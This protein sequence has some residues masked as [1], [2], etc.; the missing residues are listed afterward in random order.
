MSDETVRGDETVRSQETE[1][2]R[3]AVDFFA[4]TQCA[5]VSPFYE[6]VCRY[7]VTDD[8]MLELLLAAPLEQR[9]P[10]L[11]FGA[12]NHLVTLHRDDP[13]AGYFPNLGGAVASDAVLGR[14]LTRFVH[15]HGDHFRQLL[16]TRTT[17]TNDVRRSYV[18]GTGLSAAAQH[19]P[20]PLDVVELGASAGLNLL[21][22]RYRHTVNDE[23]VF[24]PARAET[25]E[26]RILGKGGKGEPGDS[27]PAENADGPGNH[28]WPIARTRTGVDLQP[29]DIRESEDRAWL[30][31]FVWPE[32]TEELRTLDAAIAVARADGPPPVLKADALAY[33]GRLAESPHDGSSLVVFTCSLLTY[34][35]A[36]RSRRILRH[37]QA[38]ARTRPVAWLYAES[39]LLA[40][41][42]GLA[43]PELAGELGQVAETYAIGLTVLTGDRRQ[44]MLLG[45]ADPYLR[46][47][48]SV[49]GRK[50]RHGG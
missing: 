50:E 19:M 6:Q 18:L 37:L 29:V 44:D 12:L 40:R 39:P 23:T 7:L 9:R 33:L 30:R 11:F 3:R 47:I 4:R 8:A 2:L 49:P 25:C 5:G 35:T 46:W 14:E 10:S 15:Q 41:T 22:D 28:P 16:G 26:I 21:Y 20:A 42:A 31:S 27:G 36:A 43:P 1:R 34:L 45:I 13:L 17:Q 38:V 48:E 32:M 24:S